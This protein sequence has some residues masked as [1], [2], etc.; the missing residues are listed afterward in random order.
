MSQH[1]NPLT[2]GLSLGQIR[3]ERD[4]TGVVSFKSVPFAAPPVG[5]LRWA[6][7]QPPIPWEGVRDATRFA[8]N[9][10]QA[11]MPRGSILAQFHHC[12]DNHVAGRQET[13]IND[14]AGKASNPGPDVDHPMSE[15]CLYLN[16]WTPDLRFDATLPVL[17]FICGGGHRF[18]SASADVSNGAALA[19][20]GVIVVTLAYRVGAFGYLAHPELRSDGTS[21]NYA[22]SDVI[23]GL[24]WVQTHITD[25]GGDPKRVTVMG[26]SAGA[27]HVSALMAAPSA[28]GLFLRAVATSGGRM[29]GGPLGQL[30]D[31]KTA[32]TK[33][34]ALAKSLG[35][36][37]ARDLRALPASHLTKLQHQWNLIV[38]GK[39]LPTDIDTAFRTARQPKVPMMLGFTRD[40]GSAFPAPDMQSVTGF[41]AALHQQFPDDIAAALIAQ[42]DLSDDAAALRS[43][44]EFQRDTRFAY[45]VIQMA[46][47]HR[48]NGG[49]QC[50]VFRFDHAP[51]WP[52]GTEFAQPTPPGG[53]GA[54][55]GAELWYFF[56]NLDYAP[57]QVTR[58]D[59]DLA[60]DMASAL[61]AFLRTA[62]P[63]YAA[64]GS[65]SPYSYGKLPL[66]AR[67]FGTAEPARRL[68]NQSVLDS[69][70]AHYNPTEN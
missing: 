58:A 57:F 8:P 44:Y 38:D 10:M 59:R 40:D 3:G 43:S 46:R 51:R 35:A 26:Q 27:A 53:F 50:F 42:Y 63:N 52:E 45:Q 13:G 69:L 14:P 61:V 5:E 67:H 70:H 32:E 29:T 18:G 54:Y 2:V 56:D 24:K 12:T 30:D 15:D 33:G 65:W 34:V 1:E 7:A 60:D 19:A 17:V 6:P 31:L 36:Q 28:K 20:R 68:D 37:T 55:H 23:A 66:V 4:E 39:T 22:L 64:P 41:K 25:F 48:A 16:I 47:A 49:A 62:D 11:D 9:P 21:G